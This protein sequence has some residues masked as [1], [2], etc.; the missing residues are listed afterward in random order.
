MSC[1][2]YRFS[3]KVLKDVEVEVEDEIDLGTNHIE[4]E[5]VQFDNLII[6]TYFII[7]GIN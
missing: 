7:Y 5:K 1:Y 2:L 4:E 6:L 3:L